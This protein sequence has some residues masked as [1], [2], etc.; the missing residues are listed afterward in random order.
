MTIQDYIK[1]VDSLRT[2][3]E[4]KTYEVEVFLQNYTAKQRNPSLDRA[5]GFWYDLIDEKSIQWTLTLVKAFR[6]KKKIEL[7][8]DKQTEEILEVKVIDG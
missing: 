5:Q 2:K 3:N 4:G 8:I 7:H 1:R 6:D